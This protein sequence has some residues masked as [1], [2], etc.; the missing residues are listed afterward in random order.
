MQ[1]LSPISVCMVSGA[2]ATRIART[3][4]SVSGWVSEIV[5]VLNAEVTDATE[6]IATRYGAR[7]F[8]EPWKGF[9]EQKNSAAEKT[10][11]KWLLNLDADE[12]VP[13]ELRD[14][15]LAL[16]KPG[17]PACSAY[18]FPR[19]SF[20]F[21]RWI[22][23]GDW[24]P[25]RCVRLWQRDSGRWVGI[26]PHAGLEVR[27]KIGALRQDLLHYTAD[28]LNHQVAKTVRYADA[29]VLHCAQTGR[30]ITVADLALRPAWRFFRAYFLKLGF[31]DG[32]QGYTI[33][34][35]TAFYTFLRYA[36]AREAQAATKANA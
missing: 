6:E 32:W 2:E 23:H 10:T 31:L 8:R 22:G 7:V 3:L 36:R 24:Y 29:F 19:R 34:W 16:F 13:P 4:E 25:D 12:V 18:S 14:E 27:G 35:L 30:R 11:G 9:V 21:G 5:I 28:T 17:L 20:Y 15:I 33:A 1:K 26:D